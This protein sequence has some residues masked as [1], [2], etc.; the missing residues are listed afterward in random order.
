[1]SK[2]EAVKQG[3]VVGMRIK[4]MSE[5]AKEMRASYHTQEYGGQENTL[6][7]RWSM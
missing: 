1:M 3:H 6:S 2:M 7:V 5:E 4:G